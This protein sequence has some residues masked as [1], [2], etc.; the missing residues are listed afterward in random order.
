LAPDYRGYG[1]SE[2]VRGRHRPLEQVQDTYDAVTYLTT[3]AGVDPERIGIYG[4]SFGGAVAIWAAAFD[5]R[6][7]AVVSAAGVHDGERWLKT[8]RAPNDW[9]KFRDRVREEA[10]HRVLTGEKAMIFRYDIYPN[11][12]EIVEKP[13]MTK[14]K[15]GSDD[16]LEVDMAS[17]EACLR[18]KAEWFVD[19]IAPRPVLFFA[20]E[21]DIMVPP[22]E[23]YEAFAKCGE[24]KRLIELRG[25]RHNH[26]YEFSDS[27]HFR[28]VAN[29]TAAWFKK[30]L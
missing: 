17:V 4:T 28:T 21:Y 5:Q 3:V 29:E 2:G 15:Y 8:V 25:A 24:P 16:V 6:I 27:E 20:V 26:I 30:Y 7:K 11:D 18:F 14:E 22:E 23:A 9:Y 1:E 12:P 13:V 19:R 10:K